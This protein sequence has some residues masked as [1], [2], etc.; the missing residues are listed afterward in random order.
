MKAYLRRVAISATALFLLIAL[1]APVISASD[2]TNTSGA[3]AGSTAGIIAQDPYALVEPVYEAKE[4]YTNADEAQVGSTA[5]NVAPA[6]PVFEGDDKDAEPEIQMGPAQET[7]EISAGMPQE[8]EN[9]TSPDFSEPA[10]KNDK[11]K[12]TPPA[13]GFWRNL[14]RKVP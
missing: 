10:K 3:L 13:I 9:P 4:E 11:G 8:D 14:L 6:D 1:V 7:E 12:L 2:Y 5:D